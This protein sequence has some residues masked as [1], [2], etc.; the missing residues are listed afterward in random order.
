VTTT[1]AAS[2]GSST[3][4]YPLEVTITPPPMNDFDGSKLT[5]LCG[6]FELFYNQK[7]YK[8][9]LTISQ[10]WKLEKFLIDFNAVNG[11]RGKKLFKRE[12][13]G[14]PEL[15]WYKVFGALI[16]NESFF[17]TPCGLTGTDLVLVAILET[18]C[19]NPVSEALVYNRETHEVHILKKASKW[20]SLYKCD[21]SET[22]DD[23][24]MRR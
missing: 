11:S 12:N 6:R 7:D 14:I 3:A 4:S 24:L 5:E 18:R 21:V 19:N 1:P 17:V 23:D 9:T 10:N 13:T 8:K 2:T 16:T 15:Y 20:Q 22:F